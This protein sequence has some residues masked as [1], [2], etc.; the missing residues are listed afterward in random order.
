MPYRILS[1]DGGGVRGVLTTL[2]VERL[3]REHPAFLKQVD[4]IAGTSSGGILALGLAA[5]RTP[6]ECNQVYQARGA[7]VF[8][9]SL[10]DNIHDLGVLRGAQYS[11]TKLKEALIDLFGGLTLGEL[12]KQVLIASFELDNH[13]REPDGHRHWKPKFFHNTPGAGA[14]ADQKVVDVALRTSAAPTYFPIYQGYIDGGVVAPNPSM[15]ALAQAINPQAAAQSLDEI[16]LI[17]IGT[18]RTSN[19]LTEQDADW[20]LLQ[21]APHLLGIVTEASLSLPDYQCRQILG[22]RYHRL[23]P[24]L[25]KA[26]RLD[27]VQ[28]AVYLAD[29]AE[30]A[31]LS[32]TRQWLS[33]YF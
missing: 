20:G 33:R 29:L 11:N 15:C 30:Q 14:D 5:G 17:S 1:F 25:P 4:L 22:E 10:L 8:G 12:P 32:A 13:N 24:D 6:D 19:Y 16:A 2:L 7:Q 9:D 3:T 28:Q 26:V 21:W 27:D 23:N 31:D 18:G